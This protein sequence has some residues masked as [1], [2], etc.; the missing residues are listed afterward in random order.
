MSLL[1]TALLAEHE[2]I[3]RAQA[4]ARFVACL[5]PES[6]VSV[7]N[8]TSNMDC[9]SWVARA[10]VGQATIPGSSIPAHSGLLGQLSSLASPA[11]VPTG[12][13]VW[14]STAYCRAHVTMLH[15]LKETPDFRPIQ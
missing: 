10:T 3:P 4:L 11:L 1:A 7:Y 8:L 5:L 15:T 13:Y 14:T 6:A 9:P 12:N 2:V